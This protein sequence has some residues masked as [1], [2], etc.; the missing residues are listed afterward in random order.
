MKEF[1]V[2]VSRTDT[3]KIKIDENNVD[4]VIKKYNEYFA[5]KLNKTNE[6]KDLAKHIGI[7]SM[8]NSDRSFEGLGTIVIDNFPSED[9]LGYE[10]DN[11]VKGIEI[12][13]ISSDYMDTN[14]EEI[15]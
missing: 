10:E 6:I 2:T 3:F 13:T 11:V 7:M 12:E 14:I 9:C 1:E 8:D 4:E 15:K 5:E